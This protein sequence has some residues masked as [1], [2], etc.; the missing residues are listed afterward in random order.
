MKKGI[1]IALLLFA[2][3]PASPAAAEGGVNLLL[4]G[5]R[6]DN[7]IEISLSPDGRDYVI[8]SKAPLEVGADLC[9]HPNGDP[10]Q[11]LCEAPAIASFEVNVGGGADVAVLS[12]EIPV[13]A[14]LRGGPGHDR[15]VGGAAADKIVGGPGN[16]VL[17]GRR[18]DDWIFG[19]SGNDRLLGGAGDDQLHGG[20][21]TDVIIGGPGKNEILP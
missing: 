1:L 10:T 9:S 15:L 16:D 8:A 21:G 6:E 12:P 7:A 11:L 2:A 19:G 5:G 4:T 17:G 13:P 14:T 3:Q 18:G 20:P